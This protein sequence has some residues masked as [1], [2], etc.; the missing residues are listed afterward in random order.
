MTRTF[1]KGDDNN[2]RNVVV[3]KNVKDLINRQKGRQRSL[4]TERTNLLRVC[5]SK[6][7]SEKYVNDIDAK[8]KVAKTVSGES[9]CV[10][11]K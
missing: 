8:W 10:E 9:L 1:L 4:P 7:R 3:S 6:T 2:G 11:E 5:Y